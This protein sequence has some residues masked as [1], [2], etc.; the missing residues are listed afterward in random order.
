MVDLFLRGHAEP[1]IRDKFNFP[2]SI[3]LGRLIQIIKRAL[4]LGRLAT[5]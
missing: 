1:L 4:N 2:G 3:C 5:I